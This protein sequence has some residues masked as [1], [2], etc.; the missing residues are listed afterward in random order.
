MTM[1]SGAIAGVAFAI[2]ITASGALRGGQ[3][4]V[5][6]TSVDVVS[7]NVSVVKGRNPVTGLEAGDF[8]LEDKGVRQQIDAVSLE[9]V[10]LDVTVVLG[11]ILGQRR[12]EDEILR[13]LLEADHMRATGSRRA[14]IHSQKS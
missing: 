5:F 4:P 10:P 2:G 3:Q 6:R 9:T 12:S 14:P 13:G 11:G 8:V 7:V 1:S